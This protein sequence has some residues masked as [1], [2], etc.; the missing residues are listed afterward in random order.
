VKNETVSIE[1]ACPK[2]GKSGSGTF[3]E[4]GNPT[5]APGRSARRVE[6]LPKGFAAGEIDAF[7]N[8]DVLCEA[9]NRS[10]AVGTQ[11]V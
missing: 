4:I 11:Q 8:Q 2:C 9:C 5:G 10:A 6:T 3:E 7:G 1:V